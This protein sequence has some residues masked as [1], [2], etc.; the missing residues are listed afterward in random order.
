MTT[1]PWIRTLALVLALGPL[2][3]CAYG[4]HPLE[5][6]LRYGRN[7]VAL[8]DGIAPGASVEVF[9]EDGQRVGGRVVD[10]DS[11]EL[12]VDEGRHRRTYAWWQIVAVRE[13]EAPEDKSPSLGGAMTR[14]FAIIGA[15]ALFASAMN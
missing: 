6:D 15:V 7:R 3:A 5:Q 1:R 14:F 10:W 2:A 12:V 9:L 8:P 11:A 13:Y 4:P